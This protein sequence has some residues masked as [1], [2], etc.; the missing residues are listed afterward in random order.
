MIDCI[1]TVQGPPQIIAIGGTSHG[2]FGAASGGAIRLV[3]PIV[4]G[5]ANLNIAP[6]QTAAAGYGRARIDTT[7]PGQLTVGSGGLN[8]SATHTTFGS[9][10]VVFPPNPP[11]VRIV[12]AA[13]QAIAKG[14]TDPVFV[15]LPT[16]A[17][18]T[19]EVKV[20]VENFGTIVPLRAIVSPESG[21][22]G[23][24]DFSIDNTGG[25]VTEGSVNV[26]IPAGT[27]VRIDV[28]TR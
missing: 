5:T 20:E 15:L 2:S 18:E 9:N 6:G 25:G 8:L 24:F 13:G 10:M 22:R 21:E 12:E 23:T 4:R 11:L 27:T 28:W 3:A 7:S 14:R 19:Q 16:G 26:T 17:A 1:S